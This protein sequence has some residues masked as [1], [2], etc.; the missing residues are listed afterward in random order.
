MIRIL[1][2][3]RVIFNS[4]FLRDIIKI[5][6]FVMNYLYICSSFSMNVVF[7]P[8]EC[9]HL[10]NTFDFFIISSM[11]GKFTVCNSLNP[12]INAS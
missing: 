6:C 5:N 9:Y 12:V 2:P 4:V 8:Q 11:H 10:I 1:R 3:V 7:D